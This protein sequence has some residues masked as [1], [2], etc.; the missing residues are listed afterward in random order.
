MHKHSCCAGHLPWELKRQLTDSSGKQ[1]KGPYITKAGG[2]AKKYNVGRQ[3]F[4]SFNNELPKGDV[5]GF[6][7]GDG[8]YCNEV[9]REEAYDNHPAAHWRHYFEAYRAGNYP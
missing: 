6:M 1:L 9:G 3:Y 7:W 5:S 8:S 2:G 4:S